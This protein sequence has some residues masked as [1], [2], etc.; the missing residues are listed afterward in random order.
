MGYSLTLRYMTLADVPAVFQL[1]VLSFATP[2]TQRSFI[3]EV[4]ENDA[5]HMIVLEDA[6]AGIIAFG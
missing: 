5:S 2:W 6:T 1:E 4:T 3:F